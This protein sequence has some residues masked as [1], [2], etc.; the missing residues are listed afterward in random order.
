VF[1]GLGCYT[2]DSAGLSIGP[3][4]D[5]GQAAAKNELAPDKVAQACLA[6]GKALEE[7][8]YDREAI[9]EYEKARQNNP[10]LKDLSMR[11]AIL[12]DRQGDP[13]HAMAEFNKALALHPSDPDLLNDVGYHY[14]EAGDL[15][16]AEK[17]LRKAVAAKAS[18]QRAWVNLGIVLGKQGR[19]EESYGAFA[20]ALTPA[21]A[22]ANVGIILVKQ[23]RIE[24][25][26]KEL[27][28]ALAMD[29]S[30]EQA[31]AVLKVLESPGG[32]ATK[33]AEQPVTGTGSASQ[34]PA[35]SN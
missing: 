30:V 10:A 1:P 11:L 8:G 21:Q 27:R 28:Q 34:A 9:L 20:K 29:A 16:E 22:R 19:Y 33:I 5:E 25:A 13:V 35:G 12:Y 18:C 3:E 4:K 31:R 26:K 14:Y 7:N 23:G 6:S 24:D 15:P 17:W 32:T 2:F